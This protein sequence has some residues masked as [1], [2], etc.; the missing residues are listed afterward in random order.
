MYILPDSLNTAA[1]VL[2]V[3]FDKHHVNV[4]LLQMLVLCQ[5]E[6]WFEETAVEK[7]EV[8]ILQHP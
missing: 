1:E 8:F 2:Q 3:T 7:L 4:L 5:N 6:A